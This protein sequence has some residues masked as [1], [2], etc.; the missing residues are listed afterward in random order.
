MS[1]APAVR[2]CTAAL[3]T[4]FYADHEQRKPAPSALVE[5]K[6]SRIRA[7]PSNSMTYS[8]GL[9]DRPPRGALVTTTTAAYSM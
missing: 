1:C 6:S 9:R 3:D 4:R 5:C 7:R 8:Q 2:L